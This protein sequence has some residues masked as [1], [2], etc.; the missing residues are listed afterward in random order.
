VTLKYVYRAFNTC[1]LGL[2]Y[3]KYA[4]VAL[5]IVLVKYFSSFEKHVTNVD[6]YIHMS[7]FII[8]NAH[9]YTLSL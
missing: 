4:R 5:S 2:L 7:T 3:K 1:F 6:V 8:I 9:T